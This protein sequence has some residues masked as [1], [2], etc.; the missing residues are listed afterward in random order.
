MQKIIEIILEPINIVFLIIMITIF[1]ISIKFH[2]SQKNNIY[3]EIFSVSKV[4]NYLTMLWM[5]GTFL[6]IIFGLYYF[7][8]KNISDS[9]PELLNWLKTA[10]F[11]SIIWLV[12]SLL[13]SFI[14]SFKET[15]ENYS[16]ED[17]IEKILI[18]NENFN[19]NIF[20]I[21]N[22]FLDWFK[23]FSENFSKTNERIIEKLATIIENTNKIKIS[24]EKLDD[25]KTV[26]NSNSENVLNENKKVNENLISISDK[27]SE[28]NK[29]NSDIL[30]ETKENNN[31][32]EILEIWNVFK[33]EQSAMREQF[34][35]F[36]D[37]MANNNVKAL[38]E[39]VEQVMRD[40]NTKINEQLWQSFL[41]LKN[42]IDNLLVWQNE[43]KNN[44]ISQTES[45]K[46]S[47]EQL[48]SSS[49]VIEKSRK[50][51]EDISKK[52]ETF[53]W[54]SESLWNELKTLNNSLEILK[55]GL[56]EFDSI[57]K[58][59]KESTETMIN[60]IDS[61]KNNFVS[62]AENI[63]TETE[64]HIKTINENFK[65]QANNFEKTH[66]EILEKMKNDISENNRQNWEQLWKI[67]T[68]LNWQVWKLD[69]ELQRELNNSLTSLW[70][71]IEAIARAFT[72][73]LAKLN[74]ILKDLPNK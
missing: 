15:K 66:S 36:T 65:N 62:K 5:L 8:T 50:I 7:D 19:K 33:E 16:F 72:M 61:L 45:M 37:E 46:T 41:E 67:I 18:E 25:I 35:K 22:S 53:S 6:W 71:E 70:T 14:A 1:S 51:F 60:S 32:K 24:N 9:V 59:N 44:I 10:F 34:K 52:S 40:F 2:F 13:L 42:A 28:S 74:D 54:I 73:E 56:N 26:F 43:Y 20:E 64:N 55:N 11:T 17:K 31:K 30:K 69:E 23:S 3:W 63:I 68:T 39:A 48:E 21:K 27:I 29:N 49:E 12:F 47:K 4:K 38:V 57:A 58:N